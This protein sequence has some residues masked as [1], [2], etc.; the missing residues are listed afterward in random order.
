MGP[1]A[2]VYL[3][4]VWDLIRL[5]DAGSLTLNLSLSMEVVTN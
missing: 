3:A 2:L 1:V 4:P 5:S